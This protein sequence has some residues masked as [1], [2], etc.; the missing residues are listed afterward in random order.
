MT[1]INLISFFNLKVRLR[2]YCYQYFNAPDCYV[3]EKIQFIRNFLRKSY[4]DNP[5]FGTDE[6]CFINSVQ[7]TIPNF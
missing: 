5:G 6:L 4:P 7:L 2:Q 3:K 1:K